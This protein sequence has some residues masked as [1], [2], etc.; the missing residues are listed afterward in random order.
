MKTIALEQSSPE[1]AR[2]VDGVRAGEEV[3]LT[4]HDKP[5]AKLIAL[6]SGAELA[7]DEM[8]EE[9]IAALAD[10]RSSNPFRNIS[11]PVAWQREIRRDRTLPS[12]E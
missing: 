5:V 2:L 6:D 1:L 10:L 12:F 8:M 4:D 3:V 11:D 9:R 7:T